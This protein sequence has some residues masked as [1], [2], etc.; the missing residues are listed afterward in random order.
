MKIRNVW[1]SLIFVLCMV[2]ATWAGEIGYSYYEDPA[3]TNVGTG[4]TGIRKMAVGTNGTL[5]VGGV[6]SSMGGVTAANVAA[7]NGSSW[8][9]V[10]F[11]MPYGKDN[12][13]GLFAI[14]TGPNG[15]M[16]AGGPFTNGGNVGANYLAQWNGTNWANVGTGPTDLVTALATATNGDLYASGWFSSI[17]GVSA[18]YIAKWNGSSWSA[19]GSGL[20]SYDKAAKTLAAGPDGALYAAGAFT[21]IGG[22]S[23]NRVAK[24]NGSSWSSMGSG[25]GG[26]GIDY[27]EALAVAQ[28]GDVYAGGWFTNSGGVAIQSVAKWNGS[29]WSGL[30]NGLY[31]IVYAL[32]VATNGDVYAGGT[33]TNSGS[34]GVSRIA[35]WNGASW[36]SVGS[37]M[38]VGVNVEVSSL[39]IPPNQE[40]FASGSFSTAGSAPA[41]GIAQW[42]RAY[43]A[44]DGV[45]PNSGAWPGGTVVTIIGPNLGN[46]LDITNVTLCGVSVAEISSQTSSQVVVVAGR[47][48]AA[49]LGDVRVYSASQGVAIGTN[50]FSYTGPGLQVLGTNSTVIENDGEPSKT[51]GTVFGHL[52][53]GNSATQTFSLSNLGGTEVTTISGFDVSDPAFTVS[54][55]PGT[56]AVGGVSNFSVRFSPPALGNYTASLILSNDACSGIY[57]VK[58]AGAAYTLS[59]NIGPNAGGN[60]LTITNGHFGTITNVLVNGVVATIQ[61]A[62]DNWVRVVIPNGG[63]MTGVVD[64]VVQTSDNGDIVMPQVYEYNLPGVIRGD[65]GVFSPLTMLT[66]TWLDGT[67]GFAMVGTRNNDSSG[68]SIRPAGD[69]NGDGLAD[70]II[71]APFATRLGTNTVGETY[72]VYGSTN[73]VPTSYADLTNTWLDGTNGIILTGF[74]QQDYSGYAVDGAGDVN[75]D[76]YD[77]I[78]IGAYRAY[79]F[80]SQTGIA[81]KTYLVYGGSHL[82]AQIHLNPS[83]FNGTNGTVFAGAAN[84]I[85]S[86]ETLAGIGDVNGDGYADF[87]IGAKYGRGTHSYYVGHTYLVYGSPHPYPANITLNSD[88][89]NGTNGMTFEGLTNTLMIGKSVSAAGDV[90]GDGYADFLTGSDG[91]QPDGYG[92]QGAAFLVFGQSAKFAPLVTLSPTWAT[93]TNGVWF[94]GATN[95]S[96]LAGLSAAAGDVNADGFDDILLNQTFADTNHAALVYGRGNFPSTVNLVRNWFDGANGSLLAGNFLASLS[97]AGDV[98]HDGADD[99]LLGLTLSSPMGITNAGAAYLVYGSRRGLPASQTLSLASMNGTNGC[100]FGGD[101]LGVGNGIHVSGAGDFNGDGVDDALVSFS[102]ASANGI[103][104][105]GKTALIFGRYPILAV[106]PFAAHMSGGTSV[107]IHGALLGNGSDIT[108]VTLCGIPAAI[109]GQSTTSVWVTAG[110]SPTAGVGDVV[111][112]SVSFGTTVASNA[113]TYT[114]SEI[115]WLGTNG[116]TVAENEAA[117][118]AKGGVFAPLKAGLTASHVFTITNSGLAP[119]NI[120]GWSLT[121]EQGDLWSQSGMPSTLT[122]GATASVTLTY[123]STVAGHHV[124]QVAI[125]ND[126]LI[127]PWRINVEGSAWA[128]T[129][130]AGPAAGGNTLTIT[131]GHLGVVTNVRVDGVSVAIVDSGASW[132]TIEMP[133]NSTPGLKDIVV[134]TE[135]GDISMPSAYTYNPAGVIEGHLPPWNATTVLTNT[136]YDGTNGLIFAGSEESLL[137]GVSVASAGDVNGDGFDDALIGFRQSLVSGAYRSGAFLVY[138]RTEGL[139]PLNMLTNTWLDGV[140]GSTIFHTNIEYN[141]ASCAAGDVNDDGYG[142]L[143]VSA[144]QGSLEGHVYVIFG[145]TNLPATLTLSNGWANGVNGVK[146]QGELSGDLLGLGM[147]GVGDVNGDG[148]SDVAIGSVNSDPM[149]VTNAGKVFLVYGRTNGWSSTIALDGDFL[150]GTNGVALAGAV[151]GG[152]LGYQINEAGDVNQDGLNDLLLGFGVSLPPGETFLVYGRTNL[153]SSMVLSNGWFNGTNGTRFTGTAGDFRMGRS[154]TFCGDVDGDG[155]TDLLM[156]NELGASLV[157]GRSSY[158]A[159]VTVTNTWLEAGNGVLLK[160]TAGQYIPITGIGDINNDGLADIGFGGEQGQIADGHLLVVF[161]RTNWPSTQ[162]MLTNTWLNGTNGVRFSLRG[163]YVAGNLAGAGDFN[164]DGVDDLLLGMYADSIYG[165][166]GGGATYLHFGVPAVLAVDPPVGVG[167]GGYPVTINGRN[168]GNGADIYQVTLCGSAASIVSQSATQVVVTAGA[169]AGLGDV[170]VYSTSFGETVKSNGF[171]YSAPLL[172]FLGTNGVALAS[173]EEASIAAGTDFGHVCGSGGDG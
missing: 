30:G 75:G 64:A 138:G 104:N 127:S 106:D 60:F 79:G 169:G 32:A 149:A 80:W 66:N 16:Y 168:L 145:G 130:M 73:G 144:P 63:G 151:A 124:A 156:A 142:D 150:N 87:I 84:D 134:Q 74:E 37:G 109:V 143:L 62:G 163:S 53:A 89:L 161:G 7:W 35:K 59:T 46:G 25:L 105:V 18:N 97:G 31:G 123:A 171:E 81:G 38:G 19:M 136:T 14:A 165:F 155:R 72:L 92:N 17:G 133:A 88:W 108:G 118:A 58:L 65:Y 57:T 5:Y 95:Q 82:P 153:P 96:N 100:A 42:A 20:P 24:W 68:Y 23:A 29:S 160:G 93:G 86:G 44:T 83:W 8:T 77:D 141:G 167:A 1:T 61:D 78:L 39:A 103:L 34:V 173:G 113:F 158:P 129:S 172:Q 56:I 166:N 140:N 131:N 132:V 76:G 120:S 159:Q 116:S 50:L 137:A 51:L 121:G 164:G 139:P 69:V 94:T 15:M 22:V 107:A 4:G 54:G 27:V 122:A 3:W 91:A 2:N 126:S 99:L 115:S 52:L 146:V 170:R 148:V 10:G 26:A 147:S 21:T 135:T 152:N 111:V 36:E 70:V 85:Y 102:T 55:L 41:T 71:G 117:S 90:N 101:Q 154:A 6:F 9:N 33:F 114:V 162:L 28:N 119:L 13:W 112:D 128:L 48:Y 45:D 47:S 11:G 157:Y 43:Y 40:I 98:N 67:N 12:R 110:A 49:I 125:T